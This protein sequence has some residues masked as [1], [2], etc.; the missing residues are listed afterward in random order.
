[1]KR[2]KPDFMILFIVLTLVAFGFLMVYSASMVWAVMVVGK[3]PTYYVYRQIIFALLGLAL[4][5]VLMNIGP[6]TYKKLARWIAVLSFIMLIAVLIPGIGHKAAGVRRWLGPIQPSE[7]AQVGILFY[8]ANIFDNNKNK[9]QQFKRGVLLPFAMLGFQFVLIVL[10]PDMGSGM[11]LLMSGLFVI[12]AAGVK[13]RHMAA[14]SVILV[15]CIVLFAV[16]EAYRNIRIKVFLH[17][18]SAKY[19]NLGGYQIQQSLMAIYHGGWFGQGIGNGIAP[20]LYL[21]IPHE[22]FIFAVIVEELG[23]VGAFVVLALY[24]SLV[25]RG[26]RVGLHLNHRF[27]SLLAYGLSG[28]IGMGALIN[29]AAVTGLIPVTGIPLPFISYGGTALVA[30]MAAMGVLLGLSRYTDEDVPKR[31][32]LP[33]NVFLLHEAA[34]IPQQ[35]IPQRSGTPPKK[36]SATKKK[37][38]IK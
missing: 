4:M 25:W 21:P 1:M 26:I 32:R 7:L 8:L 34:P 6:T 18:W 27:S 9:L 2:H 20:Y 10:E 19:L 31:T 13:W 36:Q 14:I 11:L 35:V 15:P 12:F 38:G 28:M 22:D 24:A 5:V 17:P 30:K 33:E 23:I 16:L 37:R 29:V 3:S